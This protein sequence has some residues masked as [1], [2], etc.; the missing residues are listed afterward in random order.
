MVLPQRLYSRTTFPI[1][2]L[3]L[4]P[5]SQSDYNLNKPYLG[6]FLWASGNIGQGRKIETEWDKY[7]KSNLY[8]HIG[9]YSYLFEITV[10]WN[11][12]LK[13]Q[14]VNDYSSFYYSNKDCFKFNSYITPRAAFAGALE[15]PKVAQQYAGLYISDP[16][17]YHDS[18]QRFISIQDDDPHSDR[19]IELLSFNV[20]SVETLV[21]WDSSAVRKL[22][23]YHVEK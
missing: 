17:L 1:D 10:N 18:V 15:Y 23:M 7:V 11:T 21:I 6:H 2:S 8:S 16:K 4:Q 20:F 13:L 19:S 5:P 12:I 22:K 9:K 3:S 14:S